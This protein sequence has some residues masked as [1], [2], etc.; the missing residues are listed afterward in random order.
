MCVCEYKYFTN[1][2]DRPLLSLTIYN[3]FIAPN[4]NMK[5]FNCPPET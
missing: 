3:D 4:F 1:P 5:A 2:L